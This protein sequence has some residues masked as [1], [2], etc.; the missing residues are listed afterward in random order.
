MKRPKILAVALFVALFA[1]L[2]W[3]GTR[4]DPSAGRPQ[5]STE[6]AAR[7]SLAQL[8]LKGPSA[9][10]SEAALR[11]PERVTTGLDGNRV[12]VR[13]AGVGRLE[14]RVIELL[15][16]QPDK[17]WR[18]APAGVRVELFAVPPGGVEFLNNAVALGGFDEGFAA[19]MLPVAVVE[20][21]TAGA[22]GFEG[23][24]SG[25]Y[26]LRAR[27][28]GL[29]P[30]A[31][32]R[33]WVD[34][35]GR[36]GPLDVPTRAAGVVQGR[37]IA[38]DGRSIAGG[39]VALYAGV[40]SALGATARGTQ[41]YYESAVALDGSFR[42][43]GVAPGE[44]YDLSAFGQGL[45]IAHAIGV[46]VRAG[47]TTE[48]VLRPSPAGAL[49][50]RI[51]EIV[52]GGVR[53][54]E[55]ARV[56][57]VPR[58]LRDLTFAEEILRNSSAVTDGAGR[59]RLEGLPPGE[60]DVLAIGDTHLPGHLGRVAVLPGEL[61]S[62]EDLELH[63]GVRFSGRVVDDSGAP[64]AGCE[65][66]FNLFEPDDV[67]FD[68]SFAP[69]LYQAVERFDFPK[70]DADGRFEL[71]P[72]AAE[73]PLLLVAYRPGMPWAELEVSLSAA[74]AGEVELVLPRGG[75]ARGIAIDRTRGE[76][77]PSFTIDTV[78]RADA[79]PA[80]PGAWNPFSSGTVFDDG[81][82]AFELGGLKPGAVRL[83][84]RAPGFLE[85][86]VTS[87][88]TA[89]TVTEGVIVELS[90]GGIAR[91][92]VLL[93]SGAGAAGALV[94]A[95]NR[96]RLAE[97]RRPDILRLPLPMADD[98]N[99]LLE[100]APLG[101]ASGAGLLGGAGVRTD[102]EG[103]FELSGI[104]PGAARLVAVH[105]RHPPYEGPE[106]VLK[107]D[108]VTDELVLQLP[109]G[110]VVEGEVADRFGDPLAGA[111]VFAFAPPGTQVL[112]TMA[113]ASALSRADGGYRIDGLQSGTYFLAVTTVDAQ[114]SPVSILGK[115]STN[116]VT[117]GPEETVRMDLVDRS[118]G[119]ARV[120]GRVSR[121]GVPVEG[122]A[123]FA[124][125]LDSETM[126]GVDFKFAEVTRSGGYEFPGLAPGDYLFTY[127]DGRRRVRLDVEVPEQR[128]L[129]M[130]VELPGG[131]IAGLVV[132][133]LDGAPVPGAEVR[134]TADR[135]G[136]GGLF[137]LE[138]SRSVSGTSQRANIGGAFEFTDLAPGRYTLSV[139]GPR[140]GD[141]AGAFGSAPERELELDPNRALDDLR[142]E[143]V[144]ALEVSG[145][146]VS[147]GGQPLAGVEVRGLSPSA[148][149]ARAPRTRSGED[150]SFRLRGLAPNAE[151]TLIAK[152]NEGAES[153]PLVLELESASVQGLE[154]VVEPGVRL[155][156]CATQSTG[157]PA[158]GAVASVTRL[159]T[160]VMESATGDLNDLFKGRGIAG[161]DGCIDLG[162]LAPGRYRIEVGRA[163]ERAT[164]EDYVLE[165]GELE[166]RLELRLAVPR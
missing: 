142:V 76:P 81:T 129:L 60:V 108:V 165:S 74:L 62:A 135:G 153:A 106:I 91:G 164:V 161:A 125:D 92:R 46:E 85:R 97:G 39:R 155:V 9:V 50:G 100:A 4:S 117:V 71:G 79:S 152:T 115:L 12:G 49:E 111:T 104:Q 26:F 63:P 58:G 138:F 102:A 20:T 22:F 27:S 158:A 101:L 32:V 145:R 21:G 94:L 83:Q 95:T 128:E 140:R 136:T 139:G 78:S 68:F 7:P 5:P 157:A 52:P 72:M 48:V 141:Q 66:R 59:Y 41:T 121:A 109:R 40:G 89:D 14:G 70:T 131:R 23:V 124:T 122:G 42:F 150:G 15:G 147:T 17:T 132:S 148:G 64:V 55:G 61:S 96:G 8:D 144:P 87:Q 110:S 84:F 35:A 73:D 146:V 43:D 118:A 24:R 57:A 18:P 159:D 11:A 120:H 160:G 30:Q 166:P 162:A 107:A 65:L 80:E 127:Q 67:R 123:L 112:N 37:V 25:E 56:G 16:D 98:M 1:A 19:R 53:P 133:A 3:I 2:I 31:P 143:L 33:A 90:R 45:S 34:A 86:T 47:E 119:G 137:G 154:L 151:W 156:L 113:L 75:T 28:P 38:P 69:W 29:T 103:F 82:G 116:L 44:G 13:L 51:V 114:L 149:G 99:D 126:L 88:I 163:G 105:P 93:P 36:G 54:I 134:L 130:D 10:E 6:D 77:V